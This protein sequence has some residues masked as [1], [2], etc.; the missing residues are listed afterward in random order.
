MSSNPFVD[1]MAD[2]SGD[3]RRVAS[4]PGTV[5]A[6]GRSH[7]NRLSLASDL[8]AS[9]PSAK[10]SH[11]SPHEAPRKK[12]SPPT[13]PPPP[14]GGKLMNKVAATSAAG[15]GLN[16]GSMSPSGHR[17]VTAPTRSSPAESP[18]RSR[19]KSPPS[20]P[21]E[22]ALHI[23]S[24]TLLLINCHCAGCGICGKEPSKAMKVLCG[25]F[26]CKK[27]INHSI[28]YDSH[29]PVCK[30]ALLPMQ[31]PGGTMARNV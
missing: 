24:E 28:Q 13:P 2:L 1:D 6:S 29:C 17:R 11:P 3:S 5:K 30:Q 31:P 27:C 21:S 23:P 20:K 26:F 19:S 15:A 16:V 25:H 4:S 9:S 7:G 22:L 8:G 12:A 18:T 14:Y 10:G